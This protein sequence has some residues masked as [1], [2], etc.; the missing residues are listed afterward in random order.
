MGDAALVDDEG[1]PGMSLRDEAIAIL[2]LGGVETDAAVI[3]DRLED[4]LKRHGVKLPKG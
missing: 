3:W 2:E 4:M 1:D